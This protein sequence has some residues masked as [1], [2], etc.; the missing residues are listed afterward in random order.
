MAKED[1]IR[2]SLDARLSALQPSPARRARIR[3]AVRASDEKGEPIMKKKLSVGLILAM[4]AVLALGGV[5]LA[6]GLNAFEHFGKNDDRYA[7][8]APHAAVEQTA[9]VQLDDATL[10][11]IN[12][13]FDSAYYDGLTLSAGIV[14]DHA[15]WLDRYTPDSEALSGMTVLAGDPFVMA[16]LDESS[17]AIM[18]E[19]QD[20]L[21]NGTP[22]GWQQITVYA[23]DAVCTDEGMDIPPDSSMEDMGENGEYIE[24]RDFE[25]PLPE[26]LRN[27]DEITLNCEL[28]YTDLRCYFDGR[29][30]YY[31]TASHSIGSIRAV[32]PRQPD[33]LRTLHGQTA[34]GSLALTAEVSPLSAVL[35]LQGEGTL[36]A[37]LPEAVSQQLNN[38]DV[39][40]DVSLQDEA[41]NAYALCEG[42]DSDAALPLVLSLQGTGTLP[43][44]L[45]FSLTLCA[46][47][48]TADALF[49][50]SYLPVTLAQ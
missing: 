40:L 42:F 17:R 20:A 13:R 43:G 27:L 32:V 9:G 45:S 6:A 41:G 31:A 1:L 47:G 50:A 2:Q 23:S 25:A 4:V 26:A 34:D 14:I 33:M 16:A 11:Q 35:T 29:Q 36:R 19:W 18:Q 5:A 21:Q 12:A 30:I 15:Q 8:L 28:R 22:Y 39:W 3:E 38:A 7:K 49:Q 48:D 24:M 46:E 44:Q 10:G 37:L